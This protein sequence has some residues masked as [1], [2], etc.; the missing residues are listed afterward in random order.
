[1]RLAVV[2]SHPIQY[3]APLFRKLTKSVE[4]MVYYAHNPTSEEQSRAGFSVGFNWDVDLLSGY[5]HRFLKNVSSAPGLTFWGC[6]T[7]DVGPLLEEGQFDAVLVL[8]WYLKTF[9]QAAWSC[10]KRSIPV[11][12]R[13]DSHL[14]EPRSQMKKLLKRVLY[15]LPLRAFDAAL[16]VGERSRAYFQYYSYP[17]ER[18]F[19]APHGVDEEAFLEARTSGA[20]D[21]IRAQLGIAENETV[22][23]FV[24]KLIKRKRVQDLLVASTICEERGAGQHVVIAGS[25]PLEDELRRLASRLGVRAHFIGFQNQSRIG[26]VYAA[27]TI[28]VLPSDDE[29][30]GLVANEALA[31]RKPVVLSNAVGAAPD[32][33]G[34]SRAGRVFRVGDCQHLAEMVIDVLRRPP[35]LQDLEQRSAKYSTYACASGILEACAFVT[36]GT[37]RDNQISSTP[38]KLAEHG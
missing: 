29:S 33:A 17:R 14:L 32:L 8:G 20:G 27:S 25:G 6:D 11:M 30:W 5:P 1:M 4:L 3:Q 37:R 31:C 10:R 34:D 16:Y 23:L 2:A 13:G 28:M 19:F 35:D 7:P 26:A 36:R 18:L 22:L 21:K 24:G 9:V 15:P 12:V 38:T